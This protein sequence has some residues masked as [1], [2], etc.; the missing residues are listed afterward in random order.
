MTFKQ[1]LANAKK[2]VRPMNK[3]EELQAEFNKVYV[4]ASEQ[5]YRLSDL[6]AV[7]N[8]GKAELAELY[9]KLRSFAQQLQA[10]K[11][12]EDQSV[13]AVEVAEVIQ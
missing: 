1:R 4:Q 11:A 9:A 3:E 7:L 6:E 5:S 2:K 10:I 13:K 8:A 12:T